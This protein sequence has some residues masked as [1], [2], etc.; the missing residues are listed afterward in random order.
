MMR[1][2]LFLATNIAVLLLVGIVMSVFGEPILA[3]NGVDLNLTGL[4]I[5]STA[6]GLAAGRNM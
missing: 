2:M 6:F 3:Q 4:L 1:I 5:F